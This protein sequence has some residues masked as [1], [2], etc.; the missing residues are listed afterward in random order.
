MRWGASC[1][2]IA[3]LMVLAR[4]AAVAVAILGVAGIP[5]GA[6]AQPKRTPTKQAPK[7]PSKQAKP[8]RGNVKYE[9]TFRRGTQLFA[10]GRWAE[11]RA[12][13]EAAYAIDPRPIL[14]FNIASTYRREGD[15]VNARTYYQWYVEKADDDKLAVVAKSTIEALDAEVAAEK[16]AKQREDDQRAAEA[17][18]AEASARASAE[19]PRTIEPPL[20][21][22]PQAVIDRPWTLPR[23]LVAA[24]AGA[25]YYPRFDVPMLGVPATR[26]DGFAIIAGAYGITDRIQVALEA[27]IALPTARRSVV[28]GGLAFGVSRTEQMAIAL[29]GAF[30]YGFDDRAKYVSFGARAWRKLTDRVAI[31]SSEDQLVIGLDDEIV[32]LRLPIGF[33]AQITDAVYA[34]VSTRL[35]D[36]ELRRSGMSWLFADYKLGILDLAYT[37]VRGIDAVVRFRVYDDATD[38]VLSLRV[39]R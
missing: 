28:L 31:V 34:A 15:R 32:A 38:G 13:F 37:P 4:W 23:G 33:G 20:E 12:E 36:S 6:L 35:F 25:A 16:A 18:A 24:S 39:R 10:D 30:Q 22:Y 2:T 17:A 21:P 11:A 3:P 19:P 14:L 9:R 8:P 7:Q 1:V 26:Y 29:A 5:D 27:D